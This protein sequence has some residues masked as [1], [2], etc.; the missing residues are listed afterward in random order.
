MR[1]QQKQTCDTRWAH[2]TALI[3]QLTSL[4][5][6]KRG[7]IFVQLLSWFHVPYS[8]YCFKQICRCNSQSSI[9]VQKIQKVQGLLQNL[10]FV[11]LFFIWIFLFP[12]HCML[13]QPGRK[14]HTFWAYQSGFTEICSSQWQH[15]GVMLATLITNEHQFFFVGRLSQFCNHHF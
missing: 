5:M 9:F 1:W 4:Y 8:S 13:L 7:Q 3:I 10:L 14:K 2:S 12:S 15:S 11:W 6:N